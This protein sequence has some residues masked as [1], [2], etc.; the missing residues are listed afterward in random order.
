MLSRD[1][2]PRTRLYGALAPQG[3]LLL[4]AVR[5]VGRDVKGAGLLSL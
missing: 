3:D 2:S 5:E 4:D 1:V